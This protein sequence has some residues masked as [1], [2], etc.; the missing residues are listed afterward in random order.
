M[1]GQ[2][3]RRWANI[4]PALAERLV[5]AGNFPEVKLSDLHLQ[6]IVNNV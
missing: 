3:R 4:V 5:F 6:E 1:L 2:R